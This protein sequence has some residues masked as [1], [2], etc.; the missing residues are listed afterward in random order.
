MGDIAKGVLGGGWSL[1]VGWILPT[2]LNLAVFTLAV[3]PGIRPPAVLDRFRPGS[4]GSHALVLLVAAILLGLVVNALQTPLYRFLE[5]YALWPSAAYAYGCRRQ[6]A[7]RRR[8]ADRLADP[9][10]TSPIRRALLAEKL[11]RYPVS[12]TQVTPT[13]LGNAIRRFEEY[14]YDRYRLDTQVLWNELTSVAPEPAGRQVGTARANVDFFVALLY[15]HV[16]VALGAFAALPVARADRT[17]LVLTGAGLLALVPLWYRAAVAATDEW[18]AAV[19]TLVN[20]GRKPLAD[21]LGLVLPKSLADERAMWLLVTRMS[22]RPYAPAADAAFAPYR[23]DPP[24]P[25]GR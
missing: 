11:S 4:G 18:A 16:A 12:D 10:L 17:V 20:I 14:G 8:T 5:G 23:A 1:L 15:G 21:A 13:R 7:R 25:T 6:L 2:A 24:Q 3:A 22:N 9:A 19:R